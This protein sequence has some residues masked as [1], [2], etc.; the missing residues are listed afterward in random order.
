MI[1]QPFDFCYLLQKPDLVKLESKGNISTT[2]RLF[3]DRL[4]IKLNIPILRQVTFSEFVKLDGCLDLPDVNICI[5]FD[6]PKNH[7]SI[8]KQ[9]KDTRRDNILMNKGFSIYRCQWFEFVA[10]DK[11]SAE[12]ERR[13]EEAL[14][15]IQILINLQKTKK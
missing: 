13:A 3:L 8:K 5:E 10:F 7:A 9:F 12:I 2:E 15:P 4:E 14:L 11:W 6:G 1:K